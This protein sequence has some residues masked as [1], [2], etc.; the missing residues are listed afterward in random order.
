MAYILLILPLMADSRDT[1][2]LANIAVSVVP[3]PISIT[4]YYRRIG[5]KKPQALGVYVESK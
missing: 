4:V 3:R 1:C 5:G 2:D